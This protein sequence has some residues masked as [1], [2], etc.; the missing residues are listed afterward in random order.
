MKNLLRIKVN[1]VP[2]MKFCMNNKAE[3]FY[4]YLPTLSQD[5]ISLNAHFTFH[6]KT[7][8]S[9]FKTTRL[10]RGDLELLPSILK[11]VKGH[12]NYKGAV[13]PNDLDLFK[14]KKILFDDKLSFYSWFRISL[15]LTNSSVNSHFAGSKTKDSAFNS[16]FDIRLFPPSNEM[17]TIKSFIAKNVKY[18]PS[19]KNKEYDMSIA[20]VE[21]NFL[22]DKYTFLFCIDYDFPN[23]KDK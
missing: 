3:D 20:A 10:S 9:T 1:G 4:V 15:N 23:L 14:G 8:R 21:Q 5:D 13:T 11:T 22:G 7:G 18:I 19:K 16:I 12:P 2:I 17:I 6:S